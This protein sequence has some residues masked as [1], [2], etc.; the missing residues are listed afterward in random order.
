MF[1][2]TYRDMW[3]SFYTRY[4]YEGAKG[5]VFKFAVSEDVVDTLDKRMAVIFL[6]EPGQEPKLLWVYYNEPI[7][8]TV[9]IRALK[10]AGV[11]KEGIGYEH[12]CAANLSVSRHS[13]SDVWQIYTGSRPLLKV[14]LFSSTFYAKAIDHV[15]F[16][17]N[18]HKAFLKFCTNKGLK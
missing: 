6:K 10:A 11:I 5:K 13:R 3:R 7:Y 12:G 15:G 17:V 4:R 16:L 18:D 14:G 8:P 2:E 1:L 9:F